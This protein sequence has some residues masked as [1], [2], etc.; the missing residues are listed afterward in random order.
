MIENIKAD[1]LESKNC[2]MIL[3]VEIPLSQVKDEIEKNYAEL[4]LEVVLPGFRKGKV[5]MEVVRRKFSQK[6]QE[7]A[8]NNLISQS[9]NQVIEEKR[10]KA[11]S[12]TEIQDLK[13][14]LKTPLSFRAKI[15]VEPDFK[16]KGYKGIVIDEK[17][18]EVTLKDIER[19]IINLQEK[20]A[21]LENSNHL[22]VEKDNFVII[23]YQCYLN[24][25]MMQKLSGR[26]RLINI[27]QDTFIVGFNK[28]LIGVEKGK[29]KEFQISIPKDFF[30]KDVAGEKVLF[31]VEI[32]EIKEK[33]IPS[34]SDDFAKEIG[35]STLDELKKKI[36]KDL[37][38][39]KELQNKQEMEEKLIISLIKNNPITVPQTRVDSRLN[40]LVAR[41]KSYITQQGFELSKVGLS[42][43]ELRKKYQDES[44]KQVQLSYI[45]NAISKKENIQVTEEEIAEEMENIVNATKE[46]ASSGDKVK[47][48]EYL[49]KNKEGIFQKLM[50]RKIFN[51]LKENAKIITTKS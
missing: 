3:G 4:Q 50:E 42:D 35:F 39:E 18:V 11:V 47:V 13:F 8:V 24:G 40:Y 17:K 2:Q 36:S 29:E 41:A 49:M 23:N 43:D 37:E 1:I 26:N 25:K 22:V 28:H 7:K 48:K 6:A 33:K 46:S 31:K 51:F 38:R 12:Y 19:V 32:I 21:Q 15:E 30:E 44:R 9:L 20:N 5:P 14:D 16:V 34:I 10:I 45:F 27:A